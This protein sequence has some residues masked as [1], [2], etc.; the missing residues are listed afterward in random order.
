MSTELTINELEALDQLVDEHCDDNPTNCYSA[1]TRPIDIGPQDWT[2]QQKGGLVASL[3]KKDLI[4]LCR[5]EEYSLG[6]DVLVI[7]DEG[8]AER[9]KR[10]GI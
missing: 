6:C 10:A 5:G 9:S 2:E 3:I 4:W 8:L 1:Q 7:T